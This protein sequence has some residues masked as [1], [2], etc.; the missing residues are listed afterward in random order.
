MQTSR[1]VFDIETL[2]LPLESFDETQ[3][4]YLLK[5]ATEETREAELQKL[6][7]YAFTAQ[8]LAIGMVNPETNAGKV[9]F[10]S[11]VHEQC[12]SDNG[13]IEYASGD[14]SYILRCFWEN[15]QWYDQFITF[16]GRSFDCPFVMLRSAVLGIPPTRNLMPYRYDSNVHCDLLEQL[17]FY[18]AT[19]KFNLDFYCKAFGIKSPKAEGI[20]GLDLGP[21]FRDGRFREIAEYCIGDVFAT[22]ELYRRWEK[23]IAVK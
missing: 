7:L 2:A 14:E 3:Q 16:N 5:F 11:N 8:I 1:V 17:T 19:K 23:F 4:S 18:G 20:T 13:K 12:F 6:N 15:V 22:A 9:F 10:Q 21:L